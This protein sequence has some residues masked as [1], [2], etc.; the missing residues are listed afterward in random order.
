MTE[1]A[2]GLTPTLSRPSTTSTLPLSVTYLGRIGL[3]GSGFSGGLGIVT[4]TSQSPL[5]AS[6]ASTISILSPR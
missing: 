4:S 1:R 3:G 6:A 5:G 2:T